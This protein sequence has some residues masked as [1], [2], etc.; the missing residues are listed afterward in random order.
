MTVSQFRNLYNDEGNK[1]SEQLLM[2]L[3]QLIKDVENKSAYFGFLMV[4]IGDS[5]PGQRFR[6]I[7]LVEELYSNEKSIGTNFSQ[8]GNN[9]WS[10]ED[11]DGF[12]NILF[13]DRIDAKDGRKM[14]PKMEDFVKNKVDLNKT[15]E[16]FY[17]ELISKIEKSTYS[18]KENRQSLIAKISKCYGEMNLTAESFEA[19]GSKVSTVNKTNVLHVKLEK[20][21]KNGVHQVVLTGA[22]GT[23]KTFYSKQFAENF[24][25]AGEINEKKY[26]FVQFHSSYDYT[27]F[28][29]GLRPVQIEDGQTQFVKLDGTFKHFCR[30]VA[31]ANKQFPSNH[32]KKYFFIIDEINRA[33]L[34]R[35][36]GELMYGLEENYRENSSQTQ[37]SNLPTYEIKDKRAVPIDYDV[38]EDGFFIP[39]NVCIIAT[40][41]DIDR[42][43][44]TFDFALRRRF[45]WI[46]VKANDVM[47]DALEEMQKNNDIHK[48]IKVSDFLGSVK[49]LN[50]LISGE[51]GKRMGLS[52]AYHIGPAYLKSKETD[53]L[54]AKGAIWEYRIEPILKEYCRG[55]HD[56]QQFL[57]ACERAFLGSSKD[58]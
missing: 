46:E 7:C 32:E 51:E 53:T 33:D 48:D 5:N 35:V 38:F 13:G 25:E 20:L 18:T 6:K 29:E 3:V 16:D 55:Y 24:P 12:Y 47:K 43:V 30:K 11:K 49:A 56:T 23:G 15:V 36:F 27:D 2:D 14:S 54:D 39:K 52:E 45:Q 37:Y 40:M 10:Y 9:V 1:E 8:N 42:S 41:N 58:E 21:I 17:S 57:T 34:S 26:T 19:E 50:A 22:P 28:V 31:K 4:L 44:E